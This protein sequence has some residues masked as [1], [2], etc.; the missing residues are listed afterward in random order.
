MKVKLFIIKTE[1]H[2]R[3]GTDAAVSVINEPPI[4][5]EWT[6]PVTVELPEGYEAAEA[7][8]GSH[9]IYYEDEMCA[10]GVNAAGDP[11]I[12]GDKGKHIP[13]KVIERGWK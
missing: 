13:L 1:D 12:F 2:Y 6:E 11:V 7:A 5:R 3:L 4:S 8:D 10:C 9:Y